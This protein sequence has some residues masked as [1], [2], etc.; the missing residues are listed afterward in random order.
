MTYLYSQKIKEKPELYEAIHESKSWI[1]KE[2]FMYELLDK[3]SKDSKILDIGCGNGYFLDQLKKRGFRDLNGADLANY[4]KDK[5]HKHCV[6]DI[7]VAKLPLADQSFD[8]VTANQTLEHLENY[9]L[10]LQEVRRVLKR[11]GFFILSV[12]NQFNV[13]YR[14]KFMLTGNMTGF[15]LLNNHLLFLTR[16]VFKK[17]YLKDFDLVFTHYNR[18]PVPMLGRVNRIFKRKVFPARTRVLPRCEWFS[19]RVCFVLRK[20]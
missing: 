19:D 12:P 1:L 14:I 6:V 3:F 11:E 8:V 7:N 4:L 13:F 10:I 17:T 15:D 5:T 20:K 16:D 18:G 2:E 9:F